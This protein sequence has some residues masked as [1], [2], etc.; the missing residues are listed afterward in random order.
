MENEAETTSQ[1]NFEAI[2]QTLYEQTVLFGP[3]IL[4][5]IAILVIG[6]WVAKLL[7]N[8]LRHGLEK[9]KIEASLVGFIAAIAHAALVAFVVIAAMGKVGIPTTSFVA[10]VGAAGL[11][12]G[13]ALQGSLSNFAAGVLIIIFKP[14]KVGDY[15][16]AGGAEGSVEDIGIFTTTV[17]TLDNRTQIIP[18]AVATGGM[19]EN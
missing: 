9:R 18:N 5:A 3:R 13:L 2:W 19:I 1:I 11:A 15:V 10:V 6:N 14:Y 16:V 7:T 4:F 8:G 12:I 17:V